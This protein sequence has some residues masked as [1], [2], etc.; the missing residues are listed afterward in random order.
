MNARESVSL[1]RA[2]IHRLFELLD[3]ELA[4]V[5]VEGEIYLVGGAVMCL[6]LNARSATRG[7]DASFRPTRI[8]RE[9]AARVAARVGVPGN[10]LNDAVTGV[11]AGR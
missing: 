11:P 8:I 4:V 2:D 10:W 3:R 6:A 1:T 5:S 9:A 7:V